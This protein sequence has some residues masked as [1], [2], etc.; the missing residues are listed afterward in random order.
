[1]VRRLRQLLVGALAITVLAI[2][3]ILAQQ[4]TR[5]GDWKAYGGDEGST[6]YSPLDQINRDNIKDLRV[7]WVWK[8]DSLL[9]NPQP[10]SETTPIMVNGV[11]YFSM[12]QKRFV[13]AADATTGETIWVYRPNEGA[14]F[15]A[16][17]RKVHRGVSYWTDGRGDERIIFATPG[18]HLIALNAK[19]GVPVP[20]FGNNGIVDMMKDLDIDYKGDPNGRIGNSSPVV[21]S[22]DVIVVGPAHLRPVKANVKGDVLAYDA[23]T[24][25]NK[26]NFHT[27]PRKGEKGYE[28]WLNGSAEY[29][30]S[31]GVWGPFSADPELGY[32][33]LNTEA[34]TNDLW[35]GARPGANLYSDSLICLDIK[36]GKMIWY[37][38]MIH[39]DIWDYDSPPHPILLDATIDGV[40]R[41]L[42][43]QL[44]KQ[45]FAYVFDRVTGKE[46]WPI[47]ERPVPQT[48]IKGE[49][50]S[51]TQPFPTKPP[52]FDRQGIT[53]D[54]L[55]DFTPALRAMATQ[56]IESFRIGPVYT[57]P[58]EVLPGP[59]ALRGTIQVPGYGGGANWQSGAADPETGFVY[60]GSNTNPTGIGNRKNP[61]YN[62]ADG[63]S[64]EYSQATSP[65]P[66]ING[67][68]LLKP[69]YGR[70]TAYDMN[71]GD[72]AY[73]ITNGDTPPNIKAAFEAAGLKNVPPT[74]SPSQAHL[75]VTKNFL[76]ATEGSGGQAILHAYDKK[77][78]ANIWQ[79]AMPAGP[80]TGIPMTYMH[81]GKQYIVH[82]ARGPQGSG[83]QL[84]A[85]TVAP[86]P[87]AG[88]GGRG[89]RGG[90]RGGAPQGAEPPQ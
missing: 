28:T 70:I 77:T 42:V 21:I 12:D 31:V 14:R 65:I 79:A 34:P 22:N 29:T 87:P 46:I 90:G 78:G 2:L 49:W 32:V 76:F 82:A 11:L 58:I 4:G 68:R 69:P 30:G 41:K 84:V 3:P 62:P 54:D 1:M 23:R 60:V 64:A 20:N 18:F 74:G 72:I 48:D 47:V 51:P 45:A 33:Y 39:H 37:Y 55:I 81:Q 88:G 27:I 26:W 63:D 25:K 8:S 75:L 80:A 67:L 89:G 35:G 53:V 13:V 61:N 71:R 52:A 6:R 56:A 50:S 73:T 5:G 10:G 59:N 83:A 66:Q 44:T 19:T 16:A 38:Q 17:P 43:V 40:R 36:T 24:G 9:P 15:D 85:W 86:P 7:A 57:P